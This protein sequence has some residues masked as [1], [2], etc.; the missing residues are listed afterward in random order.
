[1]IP[2]SVVVIIAF[3]LG[4]LKG[5]FYGRYYEQKKCCF[6]CKEETE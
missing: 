3:F 6:P 1:M 2:V 5:F 4:G